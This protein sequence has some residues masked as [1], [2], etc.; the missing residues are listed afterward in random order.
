MKQYWAVVRKRLWLIAVIV[1]LV[2]VAAGIKT[3][4]TT[5]LYRANATL[6][7]NQAPQIDGTYIV[8]QSTVATNIL[9]INS[10]KEIIKSSAIMSKVN[11]EFP[12][13]NISINDLINHIQVSAASDSQVMNLSYT[14]TSY[15]RAA[16]AVNA[17]SIVF[18][19]QIPQIMKIDNVTILNEANEQANASPININA[20]MNIVAGL[21]VSLLLAI[22]LVM[23]LEYLDQS[24]KTELD[25]E[26]DLG[27][28]VLAS[29]MKMNENDRMRHGQSKQKV[30]EGKYATFN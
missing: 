13:L 8:N 16:K 17:I 25:V 2:T 10:Y 23:L 20:G 5:P 18:K 19:A 14:D 21:L 1:V 24:Y 7:V 15:E 3:T 4:S 9:L 6:I 28:P 22:G 12:E 11:A 29:V 30:G 26:S 27:L